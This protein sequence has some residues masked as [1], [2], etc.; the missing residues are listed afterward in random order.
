M[1]QGLFI[2]SVLIMALTLASCGKTEEAAKSE[3]DVSAVLEAVQDEEKSIAQTDEATAEDKTPDT[4][5]D[6]TMQE[7]EFTRDGL[8]IYGRLYLPAGE[9]PFP[10]AIMGHGFGANLSMMEGYARSFAENGIA[11]CAFDFIGGGHGVKSDGVMTEMSVLTEAADMNTV[12]D[13]IREMDFCDKDNLFV[14]GGSQ[15][16]FVATYLAGI[17]PEDVKGLIALYPAYVLQD[18]SRKRTNNGEDIKDTSSVLGTTIGRIYDEDAQ[19]FDIYD[20]MR[21]FDGN[22]LLIHGTADSIV[23][24][25]YSERAAKTLPSAELIAI[26]GAGHGFYGEDNA[27][28]TECAIRFIKENIGERKMSTGMKLTVGDRLVPVTWEDNDTVSGLKE[29][30]PLTIKMSMYGGFEQVGSIGKTLARD[31]VQMTTRPG[32]IV[33]YAGNQIVL[34]YGSNS[35]TYTRIGHIDL[36]EGELKGLLGSEDVDDVVRKVN[37]YHLGD[38][39][40]GHH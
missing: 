40:N 17:R 26:E 35:W 29:L 22:A 3:E 13:G 19:S 20:V 39:T 27:Y 24:Y 7:M 6:D 34:F 18:D 1:K 11:A 33:L 5:E 9:G 31:D 25:T 4:K 28:A 38:S 30:A 16:G 36:S 14:M 10:T 8:K 37:L 12:L 23:P 32:D 21:N 2:C 15:G